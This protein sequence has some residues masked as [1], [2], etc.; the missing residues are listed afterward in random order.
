VQCE[1]APNPE[2]RVVLGP[3]ADRLGTPRPHVRTRWTEVD[4]RSARR[5]LQLLSDHFAA[6]GLGR[7]V[8]GGEL[9][10]HGSGGMHHHL[11]TTRMHVDERCGVVDPDGRVHGVGNLYVTGGS[12]FPTGGYANPSLTIAALAIRLADHV[13]TVALR[14]NAVAS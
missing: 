7:V 1:Q 4:L 5:T 11:G 2:N 10:L 8:H 9:E 14:S 3:D 12:V 13:R 6:L